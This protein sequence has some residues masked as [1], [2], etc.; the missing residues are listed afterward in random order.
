MNL[1]F[2][3]ETTGLPRN[4]KAPVTDTKNWP[5]MV[6]LAYLLF[7]DAGNQID[8]GDYI[9]KPVGFTIPDDAARVHRISTHRAM[10]RRI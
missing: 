9:I 1:F 5:R 10:E 8:G 6:Q 4:W 2:D 7:D 3:T